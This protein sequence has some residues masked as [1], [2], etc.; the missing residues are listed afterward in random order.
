VGEG[1]VTA[2]LR[3]LQAFLYG[4]LLALLALLRSLLS[5]LRRRGG[6]NDDEH[7]RKRARTRCVPINDPAYKRPDPLIYDQYYLIDRGFNVTWDNP[8]FGIFKGGVPVLPHAL[9]PDTVYD[10]VVRVWNA[11]LDCPVASMPVHLSYLSFGVGTVAHAVGTDKIDVGVIGSA[12]NPSFAGFKWRTPSGGG[13]YCLQA[14]LDPVAD[15]EWGNNLGQHNTNVVATHSPA[16]FAFALRNGATARR[17]FGFTVDAYE[18]GPVSP[19]RDDPKDSRERQAYHTQDHPLPAGW[20]VDIV[21]PAPV[22]DPLQEIPI[23]VTV[24]PPLGWTGKQIANVH[25]HYLDSSGAPRPAGGVTV[26]VEAL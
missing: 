16:T 19:C 25:T 11:S 15:R 21:P 23:Q 6:T 24:T 1:D 12:T 8:D 9:L 22:L 2:I 4:W 5:L 14:R 13:H 26:M 17:Q 3:I 10:V 20:A 7:E 18:L